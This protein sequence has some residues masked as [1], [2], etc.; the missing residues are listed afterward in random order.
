MLI[1]KPSKSLKI[2]TRAWIAILG[3]L[4]TAC[5]GEQ[6]TAHRES[7]TARMAD[8]LEQIARTIDPNQYRFANS[9]RVEAMRRMQPPPDLQGRLK[10]NAELAEELLYAGRLEEAI[11]QFEQQLAEIESSVGHTASELT[12]RILA[13]KIRNLLAIAHLKRWEQENCVVARM[14]SRCV[15]P[16]RKEDRHPADEFAL[17][18]VRVYA[19]LL[20]PDVA[21]LTARW[22]LNV[23]SMMAGDY[24]EHVAEQWRIPPETFESDYDVQHFR[25]IA[26]AHDL[27]VLG[28]AGGSIMDDFDADGYLDIMTSSRGLRDQLRYF[29]NSGDGTFS[30][31]TTAAGLEGIV[32]GLNLVHA[33]YNND[34]YLDV[35]VLRGAW[36]QEGHPNSLLRNNGDGSFRDVTEE[37][38]LLEPFL[39]TQAASWGDYNSDGWID[40]YI[41]N[42][43]TG[44]ARNPS[45]LFRN[46]RDGTFTDVAQEVGAV[47]LGFVKGV[48]WG[49]IDNDG[50][51]DLYISRLDGGNVLLH[52]NGPDA[53]GRWS[54][55]D[56]TRE[57]GVR[58]PIESF[59]TWFW[60]YDNDGWLDIFVSGYRATPGDL[61][62]EYLGLV[63]QAEPPRLYRNNGNGRFSDVTAA[64]RLDRVLCTMGS[65]Y[66]DLDNDGYSDFYAGTGHAQF[67]AMVPNRMFRNAGGRFFQD[68]TVSGGFG[69][70]QKGHGVAFGD[71]DNDGDQDIYATM[72]GAMEGDV[73]R[74]VLFDNPGHGNRWI[75]L[76]LE[77]VRSNRAG[78]GARIKI[79]VDTEEGPRDI[80][81][82][83][84]SGGSFG[85]NSLQQEIGL[86]QAKA[87]LGLTITW[88]SMQTDTYAS[89]PM[90]RIYA[91]REGDPAPVPL[92]LD[93]LVLSR[94]RAP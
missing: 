60:D 29:R 39:P 24:P 80:Y 57:A 70:I 18:G 8:R 46:N 52:N 84:S 75:T 58:E 71:L 69:H 30:E 79:T 16:I 61:A 55:T 56:V 22:L 4:V 17:S 67:Q 59:P 85:A 50:R 62:A 41:G 91:I 21:S 10:F 9:L 12:L 66:G 63:H 86:G 32:G 37:A 43:S 36:V 14:S 47:V 92:T 88:P 73:A 15:M 87:I 25:D 81:G 45:Q 23:G 3:A 7:G 51:L 20:E 40:L 44:R 93:R 28:H 6:G 5:G 78:I 33:D 68:V 65:N 2:I 1:R 72:G 76:R 26:P 34:G 35:L 49:D 19:S 74:N 11:G 89:L 13:L 77:G 27:D 90:D 53:S 54:F 42:E 38:G 48:V 31:R 64:T 83:V 82:T 94:K